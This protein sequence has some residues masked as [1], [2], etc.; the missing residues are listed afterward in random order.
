[1]A[2]AQKYG[3]EYTVAGEELTEYFPTGEDV[4][5]ARAEINY[6]E[7]KVNIALALG[8]LAILYF[9]ARPAWN[10]FA[11]KYQ[12]P[13]MISSPLENTVEGSTE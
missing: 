1:M 7:T 11:E 4:L 6:K 13:S 2:E 3:I 9:V 12:N 8:I 5:K 10:E